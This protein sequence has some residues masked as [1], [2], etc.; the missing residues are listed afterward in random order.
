MILDHIFNI[1]KEDFSST[2]NVTGSIVYP[3]GQDIDVNT[4]TVLVPAKKRKRLDNLKRRRIFEYRDLYVR[5]HKFSYSKGGFSTVDSP[6][7]IRTK[8]KPVGDMD[9]QSSTLIPPKEFSKYKT[10]RKTMPFKVRKLD[11]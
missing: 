9:R 3:I 6:G 4:S 5:P 7:L 1:L 2:A 11:T 8:I 10:Y